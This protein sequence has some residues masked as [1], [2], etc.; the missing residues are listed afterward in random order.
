MGAALSGVGREMMSAA[1]NRWLGT[2]N[3]MKNIKCI[4][5]NMDSKKNT[6]LRPKTTP[7]RALYLRPI[8]LKGAGWLNLSSDIGSLGVAFDYESVFGLVPKT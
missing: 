6:D 5:E 7:C 4:N 1:I 3:S 8:T 2:A